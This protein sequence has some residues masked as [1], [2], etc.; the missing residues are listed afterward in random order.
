MTGSEIEFSNGNMLISKSPKVSPFL[1][2]ATAPKLIIEFIPGNG[3]SNSASIT[4]YVIINYSIYIFNFE[5]S[6][7]FIYK[8]TIIK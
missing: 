2:I 6:L 1:L 4:T 3:P 5:Y 8:L 7:I